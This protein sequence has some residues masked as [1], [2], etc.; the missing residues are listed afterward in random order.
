MCKNVYY[1]NLH[2]KQRREYMLWTL[3]GE[4]RKTKKRQVLKEEANLTFEIT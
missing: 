4:R 2:R 3:R 1:S